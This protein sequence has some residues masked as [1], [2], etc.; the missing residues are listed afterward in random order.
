MAFQD[1]KVLKEAEDNKE[2]KGTM[3][4]PV[5]KAIQEIRV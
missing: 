5:L 3:E 2:E 4:I 1:Q